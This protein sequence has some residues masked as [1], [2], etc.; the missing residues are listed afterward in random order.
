[1]RWKTQ[2][3]SLL[4]VA[5]IA[6]LLYVKAMVQQGVNE[7]IDAEGWLEYAR[8]EAA[9]CDLHSLLSKSDHGRI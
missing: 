8:R 4:V 9:A 1:M 2:H 5:V 7:A 3:E 6:L